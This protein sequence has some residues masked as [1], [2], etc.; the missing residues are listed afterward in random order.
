MTC[1]CTSNVKAAFVNSVLLAVLYTLKIIGSYYFWI[2]FGIITGF[3]D[4]VSASILAYGAH[5]RDSKAMQIYKVSAILMIILFIVETIL[6]IVNLPQIRYL[7][8]NWA[9]RIDGC[10]NCYARGEAAGTI[11]IVV[12]ALFFFG[13]IILKIWTIFVANNARLEIEGEP[14][15]FADE[16]CCLCWCCTSYIKAAFVNS[17]ILAVLYALK[18]IGS[19]YFW[20]TFGIITGFLGLLS[21]S[22]L[23]Y[24][25]HTH[26]SKAM[27]IYKAS[28]ILMIILFIVKTILSIVNLS[29]FRGL[30]A[31]ISEETRTVFIVVFV[32]YVVGF[33]IFNIWTIL[34]ANNVKLEIED[35][36][37][38]E[39]QQLLG[40][41]KLP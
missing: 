38:G 37:R 33:T 3:L 26:N 9:I 21:V 36:Q 27:Q 15:S 31:K 4:L 18:I 8:E 35:K 1:C 12:F 16:D 11:A 23:V 19:F 41:A 25:A 24:G 40:P 14:F 10:I 5:T 17:I 7:V 32:P 6:A 29:D 30:V 2:T 13:F 34:V 22:I 39:I 28:G 20:K